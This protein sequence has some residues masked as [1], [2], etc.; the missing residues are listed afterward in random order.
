MKRWGFNA[1][2][3]PGPDKREPPG[4]MGQSLGGVAVSLQSG[5]HQLR[6][7]LDDLVASGVITEGYLDVI[8]QDVEYMPEGKVACHLGH[9]N[10]L[11]RFLASES[12]GRV[13]A[14]AVRTA[15]VFHS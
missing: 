7:D 10:I 12:L 6:M 5:S 15:S 13:Q 11:Q 4:C 8:W 2:F 14:D 1:V 9:L 3:V